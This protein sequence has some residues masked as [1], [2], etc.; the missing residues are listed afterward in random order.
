MAKR[1]T[2]QVESIVKLQIPA[3]Q[4]NPSPPVGPA[5]GQAGLNIMEFCNAFN[6]KT[7]DSEPGVLIPVVIS[8]FGDKS[9][10]FI[11]KTPPA[12]TLLRKAAG[13]DKGSGTPNTEKVGTVTQKQIEEIVN[14]KFEDLNAI[15]LKAGIKIIEGTA[16]SMGLEV[17]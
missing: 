4:A 1:K 12:S 15:D 8:V 16:R 14:I 2:K 5:L 6:A 7:A 17:K 11:T 9:F 3:G 10:T 13:I